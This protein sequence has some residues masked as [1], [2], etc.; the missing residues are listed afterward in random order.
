MLK[1]S[2][3]LMSEKKSIGMFLPLNCLVM[4]QTV[5]TTRLTD[6]LRALLSRGCIETVLTTHWISQE[7]F[8]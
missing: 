8:L 3:R 1:R 5:F 6:P 7:R 4:P 2:V